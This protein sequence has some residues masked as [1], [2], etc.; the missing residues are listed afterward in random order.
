MTA[1]MDGIGIVN[2]RLEFTYLN[3]ALAKLYAFPSPHHMQGVPLVDLFDPRIA[4]RISSFILP[5]VHQRGRWRGEMTGKRSDGIRFPQE[6]TLTAIEGGAVVIVVRDVT[7]P[8][9][10]E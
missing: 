9:C 5:V 4:E 3:D 10:A 6:I 1:S 2:E 7:E 8:T